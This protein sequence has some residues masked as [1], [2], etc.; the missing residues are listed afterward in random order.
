MGSS[1]GSSDEQPPRQ[2]SVSSFSINRYE[3]TEAQYEA[4]VKKGR[5]T[6]AHYDDSSC[7]AWNGSKFKRVRV[8]F[9]ARN[10]EFPVVCVTWQQA[11]QYCRSQGKTLPREAEWEY[12]ARSG[13]VTRYPWGNETP[14]REHCVLK[15]TV[16]PEKVGSCRPNAWGLHDMV[17]NVWEWVADF[18]NAQEYRS[19]NMGIPDGSATGFYRII[20][21]GG[22]YSRPEQATVANRQWFSP[23][24]AEVSIG[25]RCVKR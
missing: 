10:P 21:G 12:A 11:K 7:R 19:E 13:T 15:R 14:G 4:C 20:R 22:W 17:G 24:F 2:I 3:I 5:C 9:T 18:Y 1:G 6:P 25:F 16:G 23:G 8:P